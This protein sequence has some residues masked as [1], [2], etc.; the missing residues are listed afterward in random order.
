MKRNIQNDLLL[1]TREVK[2]LNACYD[3]NTLSSDK[4]NLQASACPT[5]LR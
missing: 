5:K 3:S 2:K 4:D 1:K